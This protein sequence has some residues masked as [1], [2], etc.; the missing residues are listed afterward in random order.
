MYFTKK[1]KQM[2]FYQEVNIIAFTLAIAHDR[3]R[4][5]DFSMPVSVNQFGMMLPWP[6][7]ESKFVAS[8]KPFQPQVRTIAISTA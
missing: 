6:E 7:E 8:L 3:F 2:K 5:V 1:K 4:S